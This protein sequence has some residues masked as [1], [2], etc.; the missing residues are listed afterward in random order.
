M[1]KYIADYH[2]HT[3]FSHGKGTV[4]DNVRA[5]LAKGLTAIGIADHG[6]ANWWNVGIRRLKDFECLIDEVQRARRRYPDIR[7]LAGTEANVISYDGELD[8]PTEFQEQ[9]DQVL[10]G[11]HTMIIPKSW[12]D[13][14]RFIRL[15]LAA[16]LG[17]QR[18]LEAKKAHTQALIAAIQRNRVFAVTHPGLK[19]AIDSGK[20]AQACARR[21]TALEI[22]A[23]H[24]AVSTEFL[25]C[26]A[27]VG[28]EFILSSDAHHPDQV[29][30]L[31]PA[32]AAARR[33]GL[34]SGQIANI[35]EMPDE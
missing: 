27:D 35:C 10:V 3:T 24:G 31:E 14:L 23:R 5:A 9:L 19:V 28:V 21:Q 11:F 33:A 4:E 6:P 1:W 29:G 13:G 20:L 12:A 32:E 2:T 25:R 30:R 34:T 16:R 18:Y 26:A 15:S 22:N 17:E 8:V 7:I